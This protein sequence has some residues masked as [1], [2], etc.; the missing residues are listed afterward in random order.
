MTTHASDLQQLL[1]P[2][3]ARDAKT[4]MKSNIYR[5]ATATVKAPEVK[6]AATTTSMADLQKTAELNEA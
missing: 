3:S 4:G 6:P 2:I 5:K 1:K